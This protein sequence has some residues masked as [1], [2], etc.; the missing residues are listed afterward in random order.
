RMAANPRLR[1]ARRP[2]RV[3]AS[4][5]MADTRP[6]PTAH[7]LWLALVLVLAAVFAWRTETSLDLGFHVATGRW[8]AAHHAWPRLDPFPYTLA[9][10]A[11]ID[12]HGL[13]QLAA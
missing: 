6:R 4:A 11:Y 5:A 8:I 3:L 2:L 7:A 1:K 10:R 13:F 12:L 9:D